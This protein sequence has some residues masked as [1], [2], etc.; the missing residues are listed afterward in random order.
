LTGSA[1]LAITG[2]MDAGD[3]GF[4]GFTVSGMPASNWI[5]GLHYQADAGW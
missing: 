4:G 2:T 1:D 5:C 3:N